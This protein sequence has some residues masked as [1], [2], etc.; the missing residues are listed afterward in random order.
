[1]AL[2]KKLGRSP[3]NRS[4]RRQLDYRLFDPH[5]PSTAIYLQ[6]LVTCITIRFFTSFPPAK[7]KP[8]IFSVDFLSRHCITIA[9]QYYST[10]IVP[11][12]YNSSRAPVSTWSPHNCYAT[13]ILYPK[14]LGPSAYFAP[15]RA[16]MCSMSYLLLSSCRNT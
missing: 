4:Y 12:K 16:M 13:L 7:E 11:F 15:A 2:I 6:P 8:Q 5:L 1:M 3:N 9:L 14:L 10:R